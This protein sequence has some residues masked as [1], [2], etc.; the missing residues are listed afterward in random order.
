M[1][2]TEEDRILIKALRLEKGYG[3]KRMIK[4]F[5]ARKWS[6]RTLNRLI[7]TI[8]LTGSAQKKQR[9]FTVRNHCNIAA[10]E[11]LILSQEDQPGTHRSTRQIA[12]ETGVK[13]TSVLCIITKICV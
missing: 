13:R 2:L 7:S 5:P 4:E 12:R 9:S 6:C 10:V 3:A 1:V 11:E 8:D